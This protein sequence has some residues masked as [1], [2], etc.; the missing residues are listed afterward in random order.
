MQTSVSNTFCSPRSASKSEELAR[1]GQP[2]RRRKTCVGSCSERKRVPCR[3]KASRVV[4][5]RP[6]HEWRWKRSRSSGIH[7][8]RPARAEACS[9][10]RRVVR[11][12]VVSG[13]RQRVGFGCRNAS[14]TAREG[15]YPSSS[16]HDPP[17]RVQ[18]VV[19]RR[20][21]RSHHSFRGGQAR[22]EI[23]S[24]GAVR[25]VVV[26]RSRSDTSRCSR[27]IVSI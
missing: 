12:E 22:S 2:A 3:R 26:G 6:F 5:S 1:G 27:E 24:A 20:T 15:E 7:A 16:P 8:S 18:R 10:G 14:T 4:A 21:L 13:A 9:R 11:G 17:K 23:E 25:Q 19:K